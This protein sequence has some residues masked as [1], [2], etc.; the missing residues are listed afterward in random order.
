MN[1]RFMTTRWSLV[2]AAGARQDAVSRTALDELCHGYWFPI[3]SF[4]RLRGYD[5]DTAKDL[6]QGFFLHLIDKNSLARADAE[7]GRFRTFLLAC[8]KNFLGN[9]HE[10]RRAARRGGDAQHLDWDFVT[11]EDRLEAARGANATPEQLYLQHWARTVLAEA[12]EQLRRQY[13]NRGKEQLAHTLIPLLTGSA[14]GVAVAAAQLGMSEGA[15]RVAL[16]RLRRR[17]GESLRAIVRE[18]VAEPKDVDPEIR[19]LL[20]LVQPAN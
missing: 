20:A 18:T 2:V 5:K 7:R 11:A 14:S 16:H 10:Q 8:F 4:A 17:F 12:T 13:E 3:Y 6:T 15:T 9:K 19:E 1:Q